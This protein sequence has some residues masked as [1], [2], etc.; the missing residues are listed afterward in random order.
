MPVRFLPVLAQAFVILLL[1]DVA[2]YWVHRLLHGGTLWKFHAIHHSA[3]NVDWLTSTRFHP[4]DMILRTTCA[5]LLV[6][7]LGFS[8][9]AWL[10]L[11]PFNALYSPLVHANLNWTYGPF[12]YVLVSPVFHRWH[13]THAEEGGNS[14]FA[15]TFPFIDVLLGTYFNPQTARP[16]VFGTPNDPISDTNILDQLLYPFA[17]GLTAQAQER[18]SVSAST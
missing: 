13:H 4:V 18:S 12:R 2:Q 14:N 7:A 9:E 8:T 11:V 16:S 3:V 17:P 5:Y 10:V 1:M 6:A 15:P